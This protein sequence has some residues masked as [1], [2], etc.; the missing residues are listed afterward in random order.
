MTLVKTLVSRHEHKHEWTFGNIYNSKVYW[1]GVIP[2]DTIPRVQRCTRWNPCCLR[3]DTE[4]NSWPE[5]LVGTC[6]NS[7]PEV[8]SWPEVLVGT[9]VIPWP[10]VLVGTC[11]IPWPRAQRYTCQHRPDGRPQARRAARSCPQRRRY[12][13]REDAVGSTA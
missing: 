13:A 2:S 11:V 10:E 4:V 6:V 12:R 3:S 7:C 9:C 8:N 5:V 1:L